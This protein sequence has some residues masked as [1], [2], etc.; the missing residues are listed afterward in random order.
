MLQLSY[1]DK[2][3]T[4][5]ALEFRDK[6]KNDLAR[7]D[8]YGYYDEFQPCFESTLRA[9]EEDSRRSTKVARPMRTF[10]D[11]AKSKKTVASMIINKDSQNG[12][13]VVEK[14]PEADPPKPSIA[15]LKVGT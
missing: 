11:S 7:K 14:K 15:D 5:I 9:I 13:P 1:V 6:Y 8:Y 4:A 10:A 2:F 3:L 12:T